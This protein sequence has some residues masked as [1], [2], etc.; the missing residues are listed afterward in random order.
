MTTPDPA[1]KEPETD[2]LT[3]AGGQVMKVL[4]TLGP[5]VTIGTALLFYFGWARTSAQAHQLGVDDGVFGYSTEEY[6]LRSIDSL[7]LPIVA[8][9]VMGIVAVLLHRRLIAGVAT[10]R[11]WRQFLANLVVIA[12]RPACVL[13]PIAGWAAE[14]AW[15]RL[16]GLILPLGLVFGL[17]LTSYSVTLRRELHPDKAS[18]R[19]TP[20]RVMMT[21]LIIAAL[22][23]WVSQFA[24]VVGRGLAYH[25]ADDLDAGRLVGV[26]VYSPKDLQISAPGVNV[27]HLDGDSSE[28]AFR[29][30]GLSLL[31]RSDGRLFL[32]PAGWSIDDGTLV[33]LADDNTIRIEY[34]HRRSAVSGYVRTAP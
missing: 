27:T 20:I 22:F 29:Y 4:T 24:A 5:P 3:T 18:P 8:T 7:F 11:R 1:A 33:V 30:D 34:T 14:L 2:E 26:V 19:S 31:E 23:W 6:V 10:G 15:P 21:I 25:N 32:L 28:Y 13:L 9:A 12:A 17:L 16:S